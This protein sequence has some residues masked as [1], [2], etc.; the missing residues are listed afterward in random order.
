LDDPSK[1]QRVRTKIGA[2]NPNSPTAKA[3]FHN[4]QEYIDYMIDQ[5]RLANSESTKKHGP[6]VRV[7]ALDL[8]TTAD[9]KTIDVEKLKEL[10]KNKVKQLVENLDPKT[11]GAKALYED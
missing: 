11:I 7:I 5:E 1:Y 10:T 4:E 9:D 8:P 6:T 2:A 3:V